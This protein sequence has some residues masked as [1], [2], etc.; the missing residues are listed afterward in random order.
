MKKNF[1]LLSL[2]FYIAAN[3]SAQNIVYFNDFNLSKGVNA[4][5]VG[6]GTLE[7]CDS[8]GYGPVYYNVG[9]DDAT[10][11]GVQQDYLVLGDDIFSKVVA[12]EGFDSTMTIAFWVSG[13]H[14]PEDASTYMY[15]V[16][17]TA[18]GA[19][20]VD[21]ANTWPMLALETRLWCQLNDGTDG[22]CNF[23]TANSVSGGNAENVDW[24]SD[25]N[26]HYYS[27]SF[28]TTT[29]EQRIDNVVTNKWEYDGKSD[30]Q[31][32]RGIWK[33]ADDYKYFCLGGNQ[34]W[35]W[36]DKDA[37]LVFDDFVVYDAVL[38][39]EDIAAIM[40]AKPS[41]A[42]H[43]TG[44]DTTVYT[45]SDSKFEAITP[46][47]Y[48]ESV[49]SLTSTITEIDSIVSRYSKY[50]YVEGP[51]TDTVEVTVYDT[52]YI[53]VT[54]T[55]YITVTDTLIIEVDLYET[56]VEEYTNTLKVYPNPAKD[57]INIATGVNYEQMSDYKIN[58]YNQT[59]SLVFETYI[60][61]SL[62]QIDVSEFGQTGLYILNIIDNSGQIITTNKI[63]LE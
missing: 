36:P 18:Y 24:L 54:D 53:T 46:K 39:E 17:F 57:F 61:D 60:N 34:A 55:T 22:W 10:T 31:R 27:I 32:I 9:S 30:G 2:L 29:V 7:K 5:Q 19:A 4:T 25:D 38:T 45:V 33:Y 1:I 28:T 16:L 49:D 59:G 42:V 50:V 23:E 63:I 6:N 52:T 3:V 48:E 40:E 41:M 15:S 14:L 43:T 8:A 37:S 56:S 51:Y 44:S 11:W 58:I 47:I 62:F 12:S 35:T 20:P 13:M 26:W 21:G